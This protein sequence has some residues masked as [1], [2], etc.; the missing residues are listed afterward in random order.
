M[1]P[2][3]LQKD[4]VFHPDFTN[5]CRECGT[6]PT[7]IVVGHP[8]PQTNLCGPHFFGDRMMIDWDRW[9]DREEGTE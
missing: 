8:L 4:S 3:Q 9:N 1:D 7:V 2:L 6:L 5:E